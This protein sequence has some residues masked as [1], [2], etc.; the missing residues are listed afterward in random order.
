MANVDK[1]YDK[2]ERD[3]RMYVKTKYGDSYLSA[4]SKLSASNPYDDEG[5]LKPEYA[6]SSN[7]KEA[8]LHYIPETK[9]FLDFDKR[10]ED[11]L[12]DVREATFSVVSNSRV[13]E[14]NA[15]ISWEIVGIELLGWKVEEK[16]GKDIYKRACEEVPYAVDG[17][18]RLF[19]RD[20]SKANMRLGHLVHEG[21]SVSPLMDLDLFINSLAKMGIPSYI[22]F[23]T[24]TFHY[25]GTPEK[26]K[27]M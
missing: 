16:Y 14:N 12:N 18:H 5:M 25:N 20:Y 2:N 8:L 11:F 10:Y 6:L 7:E 26:G 27:S 3:L 1:V 17:V 9:Q 19:N 13:P 23:D 4:M 22:D 21:I 24:N 15:D